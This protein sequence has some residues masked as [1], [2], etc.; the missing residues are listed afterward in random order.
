M[1]FE[2]EYEIGVF[3]VNMLFFFKVFD[4]LLV[5]S[6]FLFLVDLVIFVIFILGWI[7]GNGFLI[8]KIICK[9]VK[10]GK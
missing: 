2:V 3:C 8:V 4:N 5:E 10:M 1:R 6:W 7:E 9:F